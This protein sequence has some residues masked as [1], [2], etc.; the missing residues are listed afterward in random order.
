MKKIFMLFIFFSALLFVNKTIVAQDQNNILLVTTFYL[1]IPED[2]SRSEFDSLSVVLND[3]VIS[4]N[5]KVIRRYIVRHQWGS[6]SRQVVVMTEYAN[7]GDIDIADEEGNKLFQKA[8]PTEEERKAFGSKYRK[9]WN[10]HHS[11]EIYSVLAKK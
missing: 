10:G 8:F 7:M 4:K 2:G 11:D 6:D 9:Y 5:S 1:D 3:K